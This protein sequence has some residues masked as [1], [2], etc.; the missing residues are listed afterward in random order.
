MYEIVVFISSTQSFQD[1][2]YYIIFPAR[3]TELLPAICYLCASSSFFLVSYQVILVPLLFGRY[4]PTDEAV[5]LDNER[6]PGPAIVLVESAG[7][8]VGVKTQHPY[9][10][11]QR[12]QRNRQANGNHDF[13]NLLHI[14]E[15][16]A[17]VSGLLSHGSSNRDSAYY[18]TYAVVIG[19]GNF[20]GNFLI[21]L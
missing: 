15:T 9:R 12:Q 3:S 2:E 21:M 11:D 7:G 6:F 19:R 8:G 13:H 4:Q 1:V 5:L 10:T 20:P 18:T 16:P 14:R 17:R